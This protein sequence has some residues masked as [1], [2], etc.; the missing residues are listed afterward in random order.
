[1]LLYSSCIMMGLTMEDKKIDDYDTDEMLQFIKAFKERYEHESSE[2]EFVNRGFIVCC[3]HLEE[4]VLFEG[5]IVLPDLFAR[6][7]VDF[8]IQGSGQSQYI[9]SV[10]E[11]MSSCVIRE[12]GI[13]ADLNKPILAKDTN[14]A[15]IR[16][17]LEQTVLE[18]LV[19]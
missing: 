7:V 4:Q 8:A 2:E 17:I 5:G 13:L 15:K 19:Y 9:M 3:M 16:E 12:A 1:M 11:T 14:Y 18:S 6:A 10:L